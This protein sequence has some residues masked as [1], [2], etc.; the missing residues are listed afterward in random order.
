V[1]EPARYLLV[2]TPA[3]FERY[4][5]RVAA[6]IVGEAPPEWANRPAPEVTRCGP[7]IADR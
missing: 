5:G 3:G 4:F 7:Q 1:G 6:E 2:C